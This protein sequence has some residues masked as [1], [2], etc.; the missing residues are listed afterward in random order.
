MWRIDCRRA[1]QLS[2]GEYLAEIAKTRWADRLSAILLPAMEQ[3][4]EQDG[5][6]G[7]GA[8]NFY[9]QRVARRKVFLEYEIALVE[10]LLSCGLDITRIHEV[11][12]GFGQFVFLLGCNGFQA[13][14]FERDPN[15]ARTAQWLRTALSLADAELTR[16]VTI[17][18]KAFPA[19][20]PRPPAVGAMVVATNLVVSA[21]AAER[22][23]LIRGMRR[24]RFVVID[25]QRFVDLR[26]E[27]GSEQETLAHFVEAGFAP[28]Q[29]FLDLGQ[30]GKFYL[31]EG[32]H[33]KDGWLRSLARRL[34]T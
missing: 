25:A 16:N 14:G 17:L 20:R 32:P 24:Y 31:F 13:V 21:T 30:D 18:P 8:Y 26:T 1:K 10:K 7:S 3:R 23:A 4:I 27:P 34:L 28:P 6:D 29:P 22:L 15:R 33:S 11:G 12:C 9:V 19:W 5:A 2:E